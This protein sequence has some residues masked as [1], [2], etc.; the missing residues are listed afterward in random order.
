ME[1][2]QHDLCI[3]F[4]KSTNGM[5]KWKVQTLLRY[6]KQLSFYLWNSWMLTDYVD[7]K[8]QSTK[9]VDKK[10]LSRDNQIQNT[11]YNSRCFLSLFLGKIL[12]RKCKL[13]FSST[14]TKLLLFTMRSRMLAEEDFYLTLYDNY[15]I[16]MCYYSQSMQ[17]SKYQTGSDEP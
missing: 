2:E 7:S 9:F 5:S 4:P 3:G 1:K 15:S 12:L 17:L 8:Q 11:E 14:L 6:F 13:P 16:F 10:D